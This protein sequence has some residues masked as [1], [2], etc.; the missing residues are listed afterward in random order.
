M[1]GACRGDDRGGE[2]DPG[3][4]AE[5]PRAQTCQRDPQAGGIFVRGGS[6]PQHEKELLL[7]TLST[8]TPTAHAKPPRVRPA[9]QPPGCRS[10]GSRD[11]AQQP[12]TRS[13]P[14]PGP[15]AGRR[16]RDQEP[17]E[18]PEYPQAR[19]RKGSVKHAEIFRISSV[20][21]PLTGRPRPSPP[22]RHAQPTTNSPKSL[23]PTTDPHKVARVR[24]K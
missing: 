7:S 20:G 10:P 16:P 5:Q 1:W 6:R 22:H 2:A 15:N 13:P 9:G 11:L 3:G 18:T 19:R 17:V 21:T 12:D 14:D 24:S 4:G 8:P 23:L